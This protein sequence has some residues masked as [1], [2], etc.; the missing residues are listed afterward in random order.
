VAELLTLGQ[1]RRSTPCGDPQVP[2]RIDVL[3]QGI[4]GRKRRKGKDPERAAGDAALE[5]APVSAAHR[6]DLEAQMDL[7][8]MA[9]ELEGPCDFGDERGGKQENRDAFLAHFGEL[10]AELEGW[11]ACVEDLRGAPAALWS[12]FEENARRLR[13]AEPPFSV[14]ALID[15]LAILTA[16]RSRRD[17]RSVPRAL[18]LETFRDRVAGGGE[19]LSLYV[20]G[21]NVA[22]FPAEPASTAQPR[23]AAAATVVQQLFDDAQ[24]CEEAGEITASHDGL[25]DRKQPLLERLAMHASVDAIVFAPVCPACRRSAQAASA[26][27][28]AGEQPSASERP[29]QDPA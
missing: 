10:E 2:P 15:R 17:E 14:G 18:Q 11:N 7:L 13:I 22:Q 9:I 20:E 6:E 29:P 1:L 19:C 23:I 25:L 4:T 26:A 28:D 21:Q 3:S 16:E 24:H 5:L 12:W 27:V 8:R